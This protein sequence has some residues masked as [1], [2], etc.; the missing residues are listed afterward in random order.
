MSIGAIILIIYAV[1][2][3]LVVIGLV[4]SFFWPE[5]GKTD[6]WEWDDGTL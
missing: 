6:M 4:A 1:C 5:E 2:A 3:V